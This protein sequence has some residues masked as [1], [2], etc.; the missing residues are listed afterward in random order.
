MNRLQR[1]R[2]GMGT[3]VQISAEGPDATRLAGAADEAFSAV[4]RVERLM[5]FH[6]PE[7]ELSRLNR[8]AADSDQPVHPWTYAVLRRGLSVSR[9][10]GGLF[11][12]SVAP[13]LVRIGNLPA[14]AGGGA[15]DGSW[16]AV[17]LLP[18]CRVRFE[19]PLQLDLGGIAKGFAVDVAVHVL[20]RAGCHAASVNAGGDLR[21]FGP[22]RETIHVRTDGGIRAIGALQCGALASSNAGSGSDRDEPRLLG[23]IVDPRVGQPS[24]RSGTV[25]VIARTCV[26]ADALTKVA[27][28]G[29]PACDTVLR[30]FGATACWT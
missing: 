24:Q 9:A 5:S 1:A 16:Q 29:G 28:L 7:S 22:D 10:S 3:L 17:T 15:G 25:T 27:V 30:R 13:I 19:C 20:R 12:M 2:P 4:S 18:G 23:C 21:R 8:D 26:I 11:D 14:P 6:D